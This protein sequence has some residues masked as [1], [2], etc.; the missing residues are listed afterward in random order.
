MGVSKAIFAFQRPRGALKMPKSYLDFSAEFKNG[1]KVD[2]GAI[3][4]IL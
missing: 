4:S 2:I 1:L 3:W